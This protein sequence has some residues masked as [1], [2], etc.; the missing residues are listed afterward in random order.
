MSDTANCPECGKE[1]KSLA[2]HW[3]NNSSHR[4]DFSSRQKEIITGLLMGD[5]YI[6]N[7]SKN[8]RIGSNMVSPNY[9]K[10]VD[11]VFGC[12]GTG[13]SLKI[14]A[15]KKAKETRNRGFRSNAKSENYSDQY[16]WTS[17][18][19][20]DLQ[21]WADWYETGQKVWPEDI[22]LTPT[23]LKHWYCG[24]GHLHNNYIEI[25]MSNEVENQ[26]KVTQMFKKRGLPSPSNY[27]I[28]ERDDGRKDCNAVW[29]KDSSERLFEYMG[30]PLPDFNYK[31][32][33]EYR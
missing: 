32:P 2:M 30:K 8:P 17:R 4:P 26:E 16:R 18:S 33:Q 11:S 12:L 5:G 25:G 1:Y 6:M 13:V 24:D 3:H 27:A 22:E 20:P 15:E 29:N 10:Y 21:K 28:S 7:Y 19:H 31:W 23:V 9:L 14:T